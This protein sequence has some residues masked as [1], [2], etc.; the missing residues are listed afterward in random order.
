MEDLES[1]PDCYFKLVWN[2]TIYNGK[3]NYLL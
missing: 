3:T 2:L 1:F